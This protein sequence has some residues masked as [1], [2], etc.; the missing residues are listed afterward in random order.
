MLQ[1]FLYLLSLRITEKVGAFINI[2]SPT[3]CTANI[4]GR[5]KFSRQCL[6]V[7]C[8]AIHV[9]DDDKLHQ[10]NPP[11]PECESLFL[12]IFCKFY[13]QTKSSPNWSIFL[14]PSCL[15]NSWITV[16][17][18]LGFHWN[19][20][21][22]F[23]VRWLSL[24]WGFDVIGLRSKLLKAPQVILTSSQNWAPLVV[25][26]HFPMGVP[27]ESHSQSSCQ[28]RLLILACPMPS[29]VPSPWVSICLP[30]GLDWNEV[31]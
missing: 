24:S 5:R 13:Q 1:C 9:N 4:W 23:Q 31:F 21:G 30:N 7:L 28:E 20:L 2:L 6:H 17:P 27:N 16:V 10:N 12:S 3:M 15:T 18:K 14:L 26:H 19:Q 29:L 25:S 22:R 8:W 11:T